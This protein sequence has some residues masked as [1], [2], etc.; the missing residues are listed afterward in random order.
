MELMYNYFGRMV[1]KMEAAA[2]EAEELM[3]MKVVE[4]EEAVE[5]LTL[6]LLLGLMRVEALTW[7][8]VLLD[9]VVVVDVLFDPHY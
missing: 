8:M 7:M 4:E 5:V 6:Q 1:L 9:T 3:M 2:V